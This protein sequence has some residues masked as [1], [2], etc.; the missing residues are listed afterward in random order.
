MAVQRRE[1]VAEKRH[2]TFS[3]YVLIRS[4]FSLTVSQFLNYLVHVLRTYRTATG[5]ADSHVPF[6]CGTVS[7]PL[8]AWLL[9]HFVFCAK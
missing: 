7:L 4:R 2:Q 3:W 8:V 1:G 9:G 5:Q 6:S